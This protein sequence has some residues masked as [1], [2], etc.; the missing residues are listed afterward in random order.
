MRL[1]LLSGGS[2]KRLWPLSSDARSKQFLKVLM[3]EDGQYESMVQ[4]IWRQLGKAGLSENTHIVANI[5]QREML[6]NQLGNQVRVIVEPARRDTFPAISLAVT[7]LLEHEKV[8]PEKPIVVLPVDSYV[9]DNFF[10]NINLLGRV[11]EQTDFEMALIGA[12][13]T[14]PSSKYGYISVGKQIGPYYEVSRFTEKPT[15]SAAEKFIQQGAL[16]NCGIFAFRG[17]LITKLLR[18][19]GLPHHYIDLLHYYDELPKISFDYAVVERL[20]CMVVVPYAG[21]WKDLGTWNT[22][23]DELGSPVIGNGK[24]DHACHNTH[25]LNE[26]SLPVKV[27]GI[28]NA[29]IAVSS[30]GILVADKI[31]SQRLKDMLT[32]ESTRITYEEKFWGWYR[33]LDVAVN[34]DR[35]VWTRKLWIYAQRFYSETITNYQTEVITVIAGKGTIDL[36]GEQ[37]TLQEGDVVTIQNRKLRTIFATTDMECIQQLVSNGGSHDFSGNAD[38]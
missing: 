11:L 18:K 8:D 5:L 9:E 22:L 29:V 31:A 10:E 3:N 30:D 6:L 32:H 19:R 4:R 1:I 12:K 21:Y 36:D 28:S 33:V 34:A 20:N 26:L 17:K 24:L 27:M 16:W 25:V 14:Y 38:P 37:M 7:Y 15:E 2:G 13:P 23:T 35:E